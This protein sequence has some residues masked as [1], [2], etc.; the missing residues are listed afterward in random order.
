MLSVW[1]VLGANVGLHLRILRFSVDHSLVS[2]LVA[3]RPG[4]YST[5][6]LLQMAEWVAR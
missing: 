5:R 3:G 4:P 1:A 2:G 6:R